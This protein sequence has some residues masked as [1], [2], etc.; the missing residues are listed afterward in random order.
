MLM[1]PSLGSFGEQ[2]CLKGKIQVMRLENVKDGY[3]IGCQIQ[4]YNVVT[5]PL[6]QTQELAASPAIAFPM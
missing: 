6:G 4:E 5:I 1:M 3:G 2:I